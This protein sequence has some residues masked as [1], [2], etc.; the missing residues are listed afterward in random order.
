MDERTYQTLRGINRRLRELRKAYFDA[1][2]NG[3]QSATLSGGG[4]SSS[5]SRI[6]LSDLRSAIADLEAQKQT[7]LRGGSRRRLSPD[8]DA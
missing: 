5:Y 6:P 2:Q 7:I 8:F 1:L 4:D 3:V